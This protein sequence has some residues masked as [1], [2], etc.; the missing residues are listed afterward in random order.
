M[1]VMLDGVDINISNT[2]PI[3]VSDHFRFDIGNCK[4]GELASY[5][6]IIFDTKLHLCDKCSAELAKCIIDGLL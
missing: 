5:E 6:I 2:K 4:C 1:K 3:S